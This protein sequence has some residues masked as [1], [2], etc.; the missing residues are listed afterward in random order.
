MTVGELVEAGFFCENIE[1]VVRKNG[2]GNW[3]QG[4][5]VGKD[6]CIYP[7]EQ[8]AE[9]REIK[10]FNTGIERLKNGQEVDI[11]KGYGLP[12]KVIAK[13]V[14][15]LPEY[16]R[17]LQVAH[18]QPRH[19]HSIH[20]DALTHNSFDLDISCYPEG[21]EKEEIKVEKKADVIEGQMNILDFI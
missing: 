11:K 9:V 8:R 15:K 7:S 10:Y 3:I 13:S 20:G 19:I 5:R 21:W 18:Y 1:V 17:K 2:T 4:Y 6:A 14:E 12:M 16:I